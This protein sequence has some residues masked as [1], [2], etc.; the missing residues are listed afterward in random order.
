VSG[1]LVSVP[2]EFYCGCTLSKLLNVGN[3]TALQRLHTE[4]TLVVVTVSLYEQ[5]YLKLFIHDKM[6]VALDS[7]N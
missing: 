2:G 4:V 7:K 6:T 3:S 1:R 5:K